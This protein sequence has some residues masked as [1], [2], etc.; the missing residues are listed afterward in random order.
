MGGHNVLVARNAVIKN[1]TAN[2]APKG[3]IVAGVP[4]GTGVMVMANENVIVRDNALIDNKSS[5]VMIV[6]YTQKFDDPKYNPLPRK[7]LVESNIHGRAGFAPN[8][9]GGEMMAAAMGGSLPPIITDGLGT[10]I[11]IVDKVGIVSLGLTDQMQDRATATPS[12]AKPDDAA[13]IAALKPIV[14]PAS[15]AAAA[16]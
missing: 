13:R 9:P 7:V 1:N 16:R 5:N 3:N 6:A 4:A 11:N 8:F 14:L 2:F 10:E 15:M 12:L